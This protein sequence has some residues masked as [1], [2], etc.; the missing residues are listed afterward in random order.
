[1]TGFLNLVI[2]TLD[3]L[4]HPIS[5]KYIRFASHFTIPVGGKDQF[6]AIVRKHRETVEATIVSYLLDLLGLNV[7]REQIEIAPVW[8]GQVG[9]KDHPLAIRM[10]VRPEI[11][12][13]IAG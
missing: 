8:V 12:R 7:D 4:I 9:G 1:M 5:N 6:S 2:I 13:L 10:K 11:S 3:L